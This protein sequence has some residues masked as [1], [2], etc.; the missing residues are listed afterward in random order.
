[1]TIA[2]YHVMITAS[3]FSILF[4]SYNESFA[5]YYRYVDTAGT[6]HLTNDY[7]SEACKTNGCTLVV[8][9][10]E[11]EAA[12]T[13]KKGKIDILKKEESVASP[14]TIVIPKEAVAARKQ[15][16]VS[17]TKEVVAAPVGKP[18]EIQSVQEIRNLVSQWLNSWKSGDMKTYG[19]CYA[20]NFKA[21]GKHLEAWIA[22]KT[23]VYKRSKNIDIRLE[24]LQIKPETDDSA[25]AIFTQHYTSSRL[26]ESGEKKLEL[27]K[28]NNEWK[29]YREMM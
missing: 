18:N 28:I 13:D 5:Q 6:V 9:S 10:P 29:I 11:D 7:H 15:E 2:K 17:S 20:E 1:M 12:P 25:T 3:I 14:E 27:R 26:K 22:Y 16:V 24:N 19:S 21:K 23:K 8:L 4:C